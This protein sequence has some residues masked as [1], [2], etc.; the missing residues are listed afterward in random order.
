[1]LTNVNCGVVVVLVFGEGTV[2]GCWLLLFWFLVVGC[3]LLIV[4]CWLFNV[5]LGKDGSSEVEGSSCLTEPRTRDNTDS[6]SVDLR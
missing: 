3:W 6:C 1:M 5:H 2:V 4:G